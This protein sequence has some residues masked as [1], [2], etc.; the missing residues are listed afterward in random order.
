MAAQLKDKGASDDEV[1]I[2]VESLHKTE[3]HP[4]T[5]GRGI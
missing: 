1:E 5:F 2:T 3:G 4:P